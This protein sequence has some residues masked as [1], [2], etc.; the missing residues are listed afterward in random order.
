MHGF[1]IRGGIDQYAR[2]VIRRYG[3]DHNLSEDLVN[4][5]ME[6]EKE[7]VDLVKVVLENLSL[8]LN[9]YLEEEREYNDTELNSIVIDDL[10]K[11]SVTINDRNSIDGL[12]SNDDNPNEQT[13]VETSS[14]ANIEKLDLSSLGLQGDLKL[15]GFVNLK[16]L[17]CS[18]NELEEETFFGKTF[19]IKTGISVL[20]VSKNRNLLELHANNGMLKKINLTDLDKL[21]TLSIANN[22]VKQ[23]NLSDLQK[24]K[25]LYCSNNQIN[26]ILDCAENPGINN[27]TFANFSK[28][29]FVSCKESAIEELVIDNCNQLEY[30]DFS[31]QSRI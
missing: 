22:F 23:L 15:E 7:T 28:L 6:K 16:R 10:N 19:K 11:Q 24:L 18:D 30:L 2:E 25:I 12:N 20:D 1:C 17:D 3:K 21:H 9:K 5:V 13:I 31:Q 27:L 14:S 8:V 26:K 29:K 4:E